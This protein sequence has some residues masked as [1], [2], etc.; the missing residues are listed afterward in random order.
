MAVKKKKAK[1]S[2]IKRGNQKRNKLNKQGKLKMKRNKKLVKKAVAEPSVDPNKDAEEESDHGE[3]MLEMMDTDDLTFLKKAVTEKSYSILNRIRVRDNQEDESLQRKRARDDDPDHLEDKYEDEV[4]G[5]SHL[6]RMKPLLPIKTKHGIV[7]RQIEVEDTEGK[8]P[9]D[10]AKREAGGDEDS[11]MEIVL[12]EEQINGLDTSKPVS[13]A[14]LFV[15]RE[16]LLQKYKFR[17]GVLSSGLLENPEMKIKNLKILLEMMDEKMPEVRLTVRKLAA[18]SLLEVFKDLLPAYQIKHHEQEGVRL[19]KTTLQLQNF[20]KELLRVYKKYLQKMEKI[21]TRLRRKRGDGRKLTEQEQRLAVLAVG[22][23]CELLVAHPYFNF[24]SNLAQ[25]LVPFLNH[26][27][28]PVRESCARCFRTVFRQDRRGQIT[29]HIVR[30]INH[31]VKSHSH[32]VH[33]EVLNVLLV[34]RIKDVNLDKEKEDEIKKKKFMTRKQKLLNMSKKERKRSKKLEELE[35]E[36]LE[37]KA[38][39]SKQSKQQNLTEVTKMVFAIYFRVLKTAPTSKI[40]GVTLEGLAKFAHC[41]NLDFYHDLVGVLDELLELGNLGHRE[42]LHCVQT[43]FAI[44]SGQGEVLNIDPLRFYAHLYRNLLS[45]HAGRNHADATIILQTVDTVLIKRRKKFSQQRLLAFVKR[46]CTLA[47]QLL[48]NGALGCLCLVKTAMQFNKSADILL[49][50]DS[51]VGQGIYFPELDEPE[52]CNA[53]ST[54][55]WELLQLKR[56]YHPSVRKY[57]ENILKGIPATGDG[58]L[59]VELTKLSAVEL[60][61]EF[62][63]SEMVFRP[64]VPAPSKTPKRRFRGKRHVRNVEFD[65]YI[66]DVLKKKD[67]NGLDFYDEIFKL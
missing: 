58:S 26:R 36:L 55:L 65:D 9:A 6:K 39:E 8:G 25:L 43:V 21:V 63:P 32:V 64:T 66:Q 60:F 38:E 22:W 19:K 62:D 59:P 40:L 14:D 31:L 3:G 16:Q 2:K 35:R 47:L 48:H 67:V 44:L 24:S 57:S 56:H 18:V 5:D 29:L 41:I 37:T 10:A 17:I 42:Q 46:L 33:P 61:S 12:A 4:L 11:D 34:L 20:E 45:V 23:L 52:Y 50:P 15:C 7:T 30:R 54:A 13:M 51:S 27:L 28:A 49:D 1:I 53:S